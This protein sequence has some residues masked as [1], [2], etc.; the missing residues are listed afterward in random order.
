MLLAAKLRWDLN[1][2]GIGKMFVF[3]T[4]TGIVF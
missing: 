3:G 4:T 1:V 2:D